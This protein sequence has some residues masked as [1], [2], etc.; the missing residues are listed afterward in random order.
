M[1]IK[2][3]LIEQPTP[4]QQGQASATRLMSPSKW[5]TPN[6]SYQQGQASATRLMSPSK[7]FQGSQDSNKEQPNQQTPQSQPKASPANNIKI[8]NIITSYNQGQA[9][10]NDDLQS[11]SNLIPQI[12]QGTFNT[13]L[14]DNTELILA[15]QS[16][17]NKR[18]LSDQQKKALSDFSAAI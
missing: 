7:W 10:Y 17:V 15:L 4:Y 5:I 11:L 14:D 3:I 16:L 8:K 1:K 2:D 12:K 13:G 9:I 18:P 6:K